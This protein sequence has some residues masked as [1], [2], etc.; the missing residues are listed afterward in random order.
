MIQQS[1]RRGN[2]LRYLGLAFPCTNNHSERSWH[3]SFPTSSSTVKYLGG[4]LTKRVERRLQWTF[5]NFERSKTLRIER[6]KGH[7]TFTGE[8][9][10]WNEHSTKLK[11]KKQ[12]LC[13]WCSWIQWGKCVS[14][15]QYCRLLFTGKQA[16]PPMIP[17]YSDNRALGAASVRFLLS[18][19]LRFLTL[20]E[21]FRVKPKNAKRPT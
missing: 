8:L 21:L 10:L 15:C 14:R 9:I 3:T 17:V 6:Q 19:D 18:A 20:S 13:W 1:G 7:P 12:T 11:F 5:K 16:V 2:Q 4:N